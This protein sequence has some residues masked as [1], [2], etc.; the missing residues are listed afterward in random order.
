MN[1]YWSEKTGVLPA[2]TEV[3]DEPWL[4]KLQH[5]TVASKVLNDPSTKVV[6]LPYYLPEFNAITKTD[7]EPLFQKVLLGDMTPKEFLDTMAA[8]LTEAQ[9]GYKQ[10]NGG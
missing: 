2:N 5:L 8:K 10:R 7:T 6:Q 4:T 9:A 3:N 1:S